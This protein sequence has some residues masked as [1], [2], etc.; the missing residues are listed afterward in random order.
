MNNP[1]CKLSERI[2]YLPHT[3]DTDRP[4]L[5]YIQ[6]DKFSL[7]VD[8]GNSANHVDLFLSCLKE[9]KL[10]SPD[11]VAITHWHW[12]HT[13]GM[14]ALKA[15]SIAGKLTNQ[16]LFQVSQ[17]KWDDQ[18]MMK[19]LATGEDIELCDKHIRIEYPNRDDIKVITADIV[20][21]Q[22]LD[23][24]LGGVTC[25]LRLIESPHSEDAVAIYIPEEKT[26][27]LGDSSCGDHY[28]NHGCY[29]KHKLISYIHYIEEMDFNICVE[30]HEL[31]ISK[32]Q[33]LQYMKEE[34]DAMS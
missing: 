5:G 2:Y 13:F 33:L 12:D 10:P 15:K 20:F 27:F 32:N 1:L 25:E 3:Q 14:H 34:L 18:S 28:H 7:M 11:Y 24:D 8:A 17:W 29:D 26:L 31:A 6:G 19:R 4:N 21:D 9:H 30:G 22:Y 16:L 23:I